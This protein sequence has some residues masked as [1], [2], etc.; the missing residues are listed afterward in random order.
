MNPEILA[1]TAAKLGKESEETDAPQSIPDCVWTRRGRDSVRRVASGPG[2]NKAA[3]FGTQCVS[4]HKLAHGLKH[5]A[6]IETSVIES[7]QLERVEISHVIELFVDN[8]AIMLSRGDEENRFALVKVVV[9][10]PWSRPDGLGQGR[11][12]REQHEKQRE[13][14]T[15]WHM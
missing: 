9:W 15:L 13:E 14:K 5:R 6:R 12:C 8:R 11:R 7:A 4:R 1:P 3:G 2:Y 10:I